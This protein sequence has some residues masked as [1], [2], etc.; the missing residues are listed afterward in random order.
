MSTVPIGYCGKKPERADTVAGTGLVWTPDTV[1]EVPAAAAARLLN[2]PD[3]WYLAGPL[4]GLEPMTAAL[5]PAVK[6]DPE[7]EPEKEKEDPYANVNLQAMT[8]DGLCKFAHREFGK[9]LDQTHTKGQL[10]EEIT[11]LIKRSQP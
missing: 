8:K 4:P 7:K 5:K 6:I 1:H 3:I 2:H 9:E 11:H 10:I